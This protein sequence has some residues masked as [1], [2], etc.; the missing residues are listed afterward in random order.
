MN[1]TFTM[2]SA[3]EDLAADRKIRARGASTFA[4]LGLAAACALGLAACVT[5]Q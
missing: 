4:K 5:P 1:T 3:G 2:R